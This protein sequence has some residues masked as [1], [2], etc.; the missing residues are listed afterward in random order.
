MPIASFYNPPPVHADA[1]AHSSEIIVQE[2][3]K[4]I[5]RHHDGGKPLFAVIWYGTPHSPFRADPE[6]KATF[7]PLPAASQDHHGELVA[8]DRS[9][10]TLRQGRRELGIADNTLLVFCSDNGG[11][12]DIRPQTV[13]GL[14]GNKGTLF[15]GGLR[16]PGLIEWPAV[17]FL[18]LVG[19][20]HEGYRGMG[21]DGVSAAG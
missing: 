2:A 6:D 12:P 18:R 8:M 17:T 7:G 4:F 10:G 14:R 9:I 20:L 11:L 13:G 15:E 19:V 1:G 3:L 5:Q 16:V 21:G